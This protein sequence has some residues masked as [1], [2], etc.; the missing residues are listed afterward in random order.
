MIQG[1]CEK[2]RYS[3]IISK[4]IFGLLFNTMCLNSPGNVPVSS[5]V[6]QDCSETSS[7]FHSIRVVANGLCQNNKII[8]RSWFKLVVFRKNNLENFI[9][10]SPRSFLHVTDSVQR[11]FFVGRLILGNYQK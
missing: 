2:C 11:S 5:L 8:F 6:V 3:W 1:N 9:K 10:F 7:L 4:P